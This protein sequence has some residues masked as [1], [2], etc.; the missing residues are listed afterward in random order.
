VD[1]DREAGQN[2]AD[3]DDGDAGSR[4]TNDIQKLGV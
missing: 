4:F 2:N 1:S 3:F